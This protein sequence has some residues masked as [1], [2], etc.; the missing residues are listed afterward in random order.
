M[1]ADHAAVQSAAE[2][3]L[4]SALGTQVRLSDPD[5]D[6]DERR[7]N[8]VIRWAVTAGTA[9]APATVI[10]KQPQLNN[11]EEMAQRRFRNEVA[12]ATFLTRL[13]LHPAVSPRLYGSDPSLRVVVLEDL[14]E[15]RSLAD[16]LTGDDR[17][18]AESVLY[19]YA[20]TLG[21]VGAAGIGRAEEYASI[22]GADHAGTAT[23]LF[24]REWGDL[25][26]QRFQEAGSILDISLEGFDRELDGITT[27]LAEPGG[28]LTLNLSDA[29]PDN[30][31]AGGDTV[32][33]FDFEVSGLGHA[34]LEGSYLAV[35]FPTCWCAGRIPQPIQQQ[36]ETIYRQELAVTCSLAA[37][38]KLYEQAMLDAC[39]YW[40]L[41]SV[42]W[43][44]L[45]SLKED[46]SWGLLS[47]RQRHIFRLERLV[48]LTD[49]A[50]QLPACSRVA[51]SLLTALR[52]RWAGD[53]LE[54]PAYPAF[55]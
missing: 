50:G 19:A 28:F 48:E 42:S 27:R 23:Y 52:Q 8:R 16:A 6:G 4:Q 31:V 43:S 1:T 21:R 32:R 26:V 2:Q 53:D 36:A 35:P 55:A 14:G 54:T 7:R 37:D 3:V 30:H 51:R 11:G 15:G 25:I 33:F 24:S 13:A 47:H 10:S 12:A 49:E 46:E 20:R 40:T 22:R 39:A 17:A 5:W 41:G 29:C 44:L 45:D 18:V 38:D 34:L 9:E